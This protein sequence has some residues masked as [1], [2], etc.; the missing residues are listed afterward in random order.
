M[1]VKQTTDVHQTLYSGRHTLA[2]A[3]E[4]ADAIYIYVGNHGSC[5]TEAEQR[6]HYISSQYGTYTLHSRRAGRVGAPPSHSLY[7]V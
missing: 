1:G 4:A 6:H 2:D 3:T 7:S 5:G